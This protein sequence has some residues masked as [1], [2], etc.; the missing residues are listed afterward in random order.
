MQTLTAACSLDTVLKLLQACWAKSPAVRPSFARIHEFLSV[1]R[2]EAEASESEQQ[3]TQKFGALQ[4]A[5]AAKVEAR[6]ASS[7]PP[8]PEA[9]KTPEPETSTS[10]EGSA[11][12][13]R[14]QVPGRSRHVSAV[15]T[16]SSESLTRP[17]DRAPS[18]TA[19][20]MSL[21]GRSKPQGQP[22]DLEKEPRSSSPMSMPLLQGSVHS[23]SSHHS[24]ISG[25]SLDSTDAL[26]ASGIFSATSPRFRA[27][28]SSQALLSQ[29]RLRSAICWAPYSCWVAMWSRMG[30]MFRDRAYESQFLQHTRYTGKYLRTLS[31][32]IAVW[33]VVGIV[34]FG[35]CIAVVFNSDLSQYPAYTSLLMGVVAPN[36]EFG[37][38]AGVELIFWWQSVYVLV[39]MLAAVVL[40]GVSI[41]A[42]LRNKVHWQ[43]LRWVVI[44]EELTRCSFYFIRAKYVRQCTLYRRCLRSCVAPVRTSIFTTLM[45]VS[46]P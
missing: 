41:S 16:S 1:A 35:F 43:S 37:N 18:L 10:E 8:Q 34:Y 3:E 39:A 17:G 31:I 44:L 13:A 24:S 27:K 32:F 23:I 15:S 33:T 26:E 4:A 42:R 11:A 12:V 20:F 6:S 38:D 9:Q 21:L 5:G 14:K 28:A 30:V 46:C 36:Y 45:T 40:F 7:S 25:E 2:A 22:A 29:L 19:S